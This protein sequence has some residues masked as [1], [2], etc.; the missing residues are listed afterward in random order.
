[1]VAGLPEPKSK[2]TIRPSAS[3]IAH[4]RPTA[5]GKAS[6]IARNAAAPRSPRCALSAGSSSHG[7]VAPGAGVGAGSAT[8][9]GYGAR[10]GPVDGRSHVSP[11]E[12]IGRSGP[13]VFRLFVP[14]IGYRSGMSTGP[15][16]QHL[17]EQEARFTR[18]GAGAGHHTPVSI[19]ARL[20]RIDV[21]SL[22]FLFI[23]IIGTGFL[24]TFYDIFDINVSF[25]QSCTDL[26]PDCT[27]ETALGALK[28][29]VLLNLAGYVVGTLVLSPMAD[30]VGR[31]N[32]LMATMALT[33]I[34]SLYN[35]LAPDYTQFVIARIVTGF[36]IGAD[37]AI[38][39]TFIGEMAPR[40]SRAKFTSVIF[41]MSGLGALLGIWLGLPLTP[42]GAPW[43][44]GLPFALASESF[45]SGW[46]WMYGVGAIL[47]L[48]A[49]LLRFELPESPRWLVGQGRLDEADEVVSDM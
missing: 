19:L 46:R 40:G 26:K 41:V 11:A 7:S 17:R 13:D 12:T 29:P 35:A 2:S 31:R 9:R 15:E 4:S 27:P 8:R 30:K 20:D 18:T 37:L 48:V 45:D 21:W 14:A 33:G 3:R 43:P 38:V 23:G 6:S 1:M 47:A 32:M 24:F 39:N 49:I 22:P 10:R 5:S 34:G 36:G 28:L 42:P 44:E 25:I 16:T